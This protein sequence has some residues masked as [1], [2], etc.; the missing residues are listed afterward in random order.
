[1]QGPPPLTLLDLAIALLAI[2]ALLRTGTL[3]IRHAVNWLRE[4][5]MRWLPV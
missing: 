2:C 4:I 5:L 3:A 1:M